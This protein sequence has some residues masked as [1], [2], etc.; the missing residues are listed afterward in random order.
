MDKS[1][2]SIIS[3]ICLLFVFIFY[4]RTQKGVESS[5]KR[6]LFL[7]VMFAVMLY[8]ISDILWGVIY[9]ELLPIPIILQKCIYAFYY[10]YS[11]VMSYHWFEY[12]EY[13]QN[14]YIFGHRILKQV[15]KLPMIFVMVASILSIWTD[16]FFFID[17]QGIYQRGAGYVFQIAFSYGYIGITALKTMIHVIIEKDFKQQNTYLI[18][19]SHFV[20]PVVFGVLQITNQNVPFLCIGIS[21]AV[22]QSYL[23]IQNVE[24]EREIS[25]SK[26]HSLSRMFMGSYYL[27]IQSGKREVLSIRDNN[28]SKYN[29][30]NFRNELPDNYADAMNLYLERFVHPDDQE[31]FSKM[32]S[33]EYIEQTLTLENQ[34]YSFDYRQV[35]EDTEVWYRMHMIAA[36]FSASGRVNSIVIGVMNVDKTVKNEINQ[37]KVIEEALAQAE[38]ANKAKSTFL[39]NMSHDIRT[40][41]NAIIGFSSLAKEHLGDMEKVGDYLDKIL[42]S[43]NHLLNLIND[44]L[45]MSRIESGKIQIEEEENCLTELLEEVHSMMLPQAEEK[46]LTFVTNYEIVNNYV[47]CDKLRLNQVLINLLGNA[48]KFTPTGGMISMEIKQDITAPKGYG[49]YTITVQDSGVG[50]ASEFIDKLFTPFEREKNSTASGIQGTGLGLSITKNIVELMGG[51]ITVESTVGKGTKFIVKVVFMLQDVNEEK[52]LLAEDSK[53]KEVSEIDYK[54]LF[55]GKRIL[56][57]EDNDLNR[58]IARMLL[59]EAGFILEEA[60][61]GRIAVD[62]VQ[63]AKPGYYDLVLMDIQM[64][65]M[66]GYEATRHIRG[67]ANEAL[68]NIPIVAMTANAF[69]EEKK[70]ALSCGMDGHIAKPIEVNLLFKTLKE[71][72]K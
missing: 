61:D 36:S 55:A 23:F 26:I 53:K 68:A 71:I 45:D 3:T 66:D 11:A 67:M 51:K 65:N 13:W 70:E 39:S 32:T 41:M 6:D 60:V 21:L 14:S 38:R 31:Y 18:M 42:F 5:Y 58:E 20:F 54:A 44:V 22:M 56:L 48:V 33:V 69:A 72:L 64:P 4:K 8:L 59:A 37:K 35:S 63:K 25:S 16:W 1:I 47:Y 9:A 2:Y 12:T 28:I 24:V 34:F 40:P 49:V 57:V 17:E 46:N 30:G 29:T 10:G 52:L 43:G 15:A 27:D 50:I 7:K 62:M 19:L